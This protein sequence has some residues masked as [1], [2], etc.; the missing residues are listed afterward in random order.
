MVTEA[1]Q[2]VGGEQHGQVY[3]LFA[4]MFAPVMRM[5]AAHRLAATVF[6][7]VI[8]LTTLLFRETWQPVAVLLRLYAVPVA[9]AFLFLY[10]VRLASKPARLLAQISVWLIA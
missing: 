2:Q 7:V 5:F 8:V 6:F 9:A 10:A 4:H 1:T 3:W